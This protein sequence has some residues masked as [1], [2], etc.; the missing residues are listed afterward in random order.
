MFGERYGQLVW[1]WESDATLS[2]VLFPLVTE[3]LDFLLAFLGDEHIGASVHIIQRT[4]NQVVTDFFVL[5]VHHIPNH[6][7][8]IALPAVG[9]PGEQ[10]PVPR[11][12]SHPVILI[13]IVPGII[14]SIGWSQALFLMLDK[15][16]APG[17]A[18]IQSSKITQGYKGT[19]FLVNLLL[20]ILIGVAFGIVMAIL[21]AIDV[22]FLTFIGMLAMI[23]VASVVYIGVKA[24]IYQ[25]L[26]K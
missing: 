2:D 6:R 3:F 1:V 5:P 4:H 8:D 21:N 18:M 14:I 23:A 16:I 24:A 17:E 7:G 12:F 19:I 20:L 15:E 13:L 22:G 26:V 9:L 11:L 10:M 25:G